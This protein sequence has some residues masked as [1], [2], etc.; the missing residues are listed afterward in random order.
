MEF[1]DVIRKAARAVDELE[2]KLADERGIRKAQELEIQSLHKELL[3]LSE[4]RSSK[5]REMSAL[6]FTKSD[7]QIAIDEFEDARSKSAAIDATNSTKIL[8][9]KRLQKEKVEETKRLEE[10]IEEHDG[11]LQNLVIFRN[12]KATIVADERRL[13]E[14]FESIQSELKS[15]YLSY[16][17][18]DLL[19]PYS[20]IFDKLIRSRRPDESANSSNSHEVLNISDFNELISQL[21]SKQFLQSSEY[22]AA[23]SRENQCQQEVSKCEGLLSQENNTLM[24]YRSREAVMIPKEQKLIRIIGEIN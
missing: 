10:E 9:L 8:E 21:K 6:A 11:I 23:V 20:L 5:Q 2:K 7:Y 24:T 12:E 18:R 16:H 22:D 1:D 4:E 19:Q 15:M 17:H 13:H 3:R 14:D